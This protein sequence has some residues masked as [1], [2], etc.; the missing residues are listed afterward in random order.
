MGTILVRTSGVVCERRNEDP[1]GTDPGSCSWMSRARAYVRRQGQGGARQ[2][3]EAVSRHLP[4]EHFVRA[5]TGTV[6][7]MRQWPRK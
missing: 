2:V 5:A 4:G 6:A 7:S 1:S 3:P